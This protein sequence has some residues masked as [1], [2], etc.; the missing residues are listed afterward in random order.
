M[1]AFNFPWLL[2]TYSL[3]WCQDEF[4]EFLSCKNQTDS[5]LK[6]FIVQHTSWYNIM[7]HEQSSC[8]LWCCKLVHFL[9][10]SSRLTQQ[11]PRAVIW[12]QIQGSNATIDF[13]H[14]SVIW[15]GSDWIPAGKMR[16]YFDL[17]LIFLL[18]RF[19]LL[20][21]RTNGNTVRRCTSFWMHV[22]MF[23]TTSI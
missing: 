17:C 11:T 22:L 10:P 16:A 4:L 23:P 6:S 12:R 2:C 5:N 13:S 21:S 14:E 9:K 8:G 20:K 19:S 3:K 15:R 1:F 7:V 18:L